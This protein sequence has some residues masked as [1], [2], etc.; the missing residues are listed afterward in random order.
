MAKK[1]ILAVLSVAL[2][3]YLLAQ[4]DMRGVMRVAEGFPPGYII[5]G[6]A[7]FILGHLVR[8]L[9][10]S[11]LLGGGVPMSG[12]FRIIALQ[13]AAVGFLPFRAGE[14]SLM[15]LLKSEH[16]VDYA[17]GAA[18]L[19]L[20]KALDFLIVVS[21]FLVSTGILPVVPGVYRDI[22]PWAGGAFFALAA[23]IFVLGRSRELYG[24]LP[25]FFREGPLAEGRFMDA[26]RKVLEGVEVIRS[27]KTLVLSLLSSLVL[28]MLLYGS[29]FLLIRGAGLDISLLGMVFL[30][31]SMSLFVNLPIHSPGGFGTTESFWTI[32]LVAMGV[33][34]EQG[35]A[36]GFACHII[37]IVYSAV[38]M[39][40]G[41]GLIMKTKAAD[42]DAGGRVEP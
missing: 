7:L 21:L 39:L 35:I 12:L 17:K 3:W 28:W 8:A 16:G 27:R 40:Y 20:A 10:F 42:A 6:F 31:T 2:V 32:I 1:I 15:Y 23:G 29:N 18:V 13:T 14:F 4:V 30:V 19:V 24:M 5:A 9:R 26:V 33:S 25:V 11:I 37:T 41:L 38:F 22:L 36:T 34:K